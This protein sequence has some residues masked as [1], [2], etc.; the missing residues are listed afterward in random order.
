MR[1][2]V[3][4]EKHSINIPIAAVA[5]AGI[6]QSPISFAAAT[7]AAVTDVRE[8]ATISAVFI[9]LWINSDSDTT[10]GSFNVSLEYLPGLLTPMTNAQAFS[11]HGYTNKKNIYYVT[12]GLSTIQLGNSMP[13]IRQWFKIPKGKQRMG[14]GDKLVLNIAS[15][16]TALNFCGMII[17]K[18]QF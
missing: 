6:V 9:E 14:L 3:H 18:E 15:L 17:Y 1:P 11:Q 16:V 13:V 8:G 7:P 2:K 5:S 10:V 12:Q 4:T